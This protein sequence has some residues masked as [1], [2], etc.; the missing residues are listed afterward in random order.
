MWNHCQSSCPLACCK[1]RQES[2]PTINES[3]ILII[4]DQ[5]FYKTIDGVLVSQ[6]IWRWMEAE[7]E[8]QLLLPSYD[9]AGSDRTGLVLCLAQ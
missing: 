6:E 8:S 1:S 3:T 5:V 9:A 2:L 4:R 7:K